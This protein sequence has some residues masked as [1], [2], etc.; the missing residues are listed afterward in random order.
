MSL[1]YFE[2]Q[3]A[4]SPSSPSLSPPRGLVVPVVCPDPARV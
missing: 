1:F 4:G 3:E 2:T